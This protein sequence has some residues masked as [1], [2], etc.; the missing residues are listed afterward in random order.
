MFYFISRVLNRQN[1]VNAEKYFNIYFVLFYLCSWLGPV[2]YNASGLSSSQNGTNSLVVSVSRVP[3]F[4]FLTQLAFIM[5]CVF[6]FFCRF[7]VSTAN[8]SLTRSLLSSRVHRRQRDNAAT[9]D[10]WD[11]WKS[12]LQTFPWTGLW[13]MGKDQDED[14]K[15]LGVWHLAK[16]YRS[17][18]CRGEEQS[19][20]T[21]GGI[22]SPDVVTT[23][24]GPWV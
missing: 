18:E 10:D 12:D 23:T 1:K 16:I 7:T 4:L 22:S 19:R 6:L 13:K 20:Q 9:E 14:H 5:L 15:R 8:S 24:G 3:V 11:S 17:W 21:D 2:L